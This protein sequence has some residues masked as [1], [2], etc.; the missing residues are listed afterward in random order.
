MATNR[1]TGVI[2]E[3]LTGGGDT[4]ARVSIF[5]VEI[6]ASIDPIKYTT[7][8]L[9]GAGPRRSVFGVTST[10]PRDSGS[11]SRSMTLL[12]DGTTTSDSGKPYMTNGTAASDKTLTFEILGLPRVITGYLWY[13]T[14][15]VSPIEFAF[16][17]SNDGSTWITLSA[18]DTMRG[19]GGNDPWLVRV[20]NATAYKWYRLREVGGTWNDS[21]IRQ[22]EFIISGTD[23]E[24]GNR[25]SSITAT[26]NITGAS[27]TD[28]GNLVDGAYGTNSSDSWWPD[29]SQSASGL[30]IAYQFDTPR[31]VKYARVETSGYTGDLGT[32]KWQASDDGSTWVDIGS[33]FTW[34]VTNITS[35]NPIPVHDLSSNNT[36]HAYYQMVGVSGTLVRTP[37]QIETY[38]D[39]SDGSNFDLSAAFEDGSEFI[40]N[41]SAIE[42][43]LTAGLVD[44]SRLYARSTVAY[45]LTL[46]I[47]YA[48]DSRLMAF[49]KVTIYENLSVNLSD[50]SRITLRP[51]RV[52]P[53]VRASVDFSDD[54]RFR[55]ALFNG[56]ATRGPFYFAW[57]E[58]GDVPH[59]SSFLR[60][61][62]E[63]FSLTLTQS[64]GDFARL[65]IVIKNPRVGLLAPSRKTWAWLTY[66]DGVTI[67]PVF[68]GRLIGLPS[69][70]FDT[71]VTLEFIARPVDFAAQKEALADTMRAL[72]Y[73]DPIFI[74]PDS[75]NDPDL[76]LDAR[77]ELW[78]ID[79]VTHQLTTSDLIVP[80]D[81][82]IELTEDDHLYH[83]LATS[84]G[85]VPV[86]RCRV[87]ATIPWTQI[88]SGSFS[89]SKRIVNAWPEVAD[90]YAS[91]YRG[92]LI[93]S[94]SFD[95][96]SGDWPKEGA[97]L[98]DGWSVIEGSLA[99]MTVATVPLKATDYLSGWVFA[100]YNQAT[101]VPV[102][103]YVK[104]VKPTYG[105]LDVPAVTVTIVPAGW[106]APVLRVGY[107]SSRNYSEIVT[108]D[109][110]SDMQAILTLPGDD[111]VVTLTVN[112]NSVSDV[113]RD[114][115]TPL[116]DLRCNEYVSTARGQQSVQHMILMAR[117]TLI[118][119][120]RAV[121]IDC[122]FKDFV[123][124]LDVT[125]RKGLLIHDHRLPGGEAVGK[126]TKYSLS[127]AGGKPSAQVTINSTVGYGGSHVESDGED[128][129]IDDDYVDD[130][131]VRDNVVSLVPSSDVAFT[132]PNYDANDDKVNFV[133]GLSADNAVISLQVTGGPN[134]QRAALEGYA[135]DNPDLAVYQVILQNLYTQV[136]LTMQPIGRGPYATDITI[137]TSDLIIPKQIDLEAEAIEVVS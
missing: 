8:N 65:T 20:K 136:H 5:A 80:E 68:Y 17:A 131:F 126:I 116:G 39:I 82:T 101:L 107:D 125:L 133:R 41:H 9:G 16:E 7:N 12:L 46:K 64:E 52:T 110:E 36:A 98:G 81:G 84:M 29:T 135:G 71:R 128:A 78:H 47:S 55:V 121:Q 103:S 56:V 53:L 54:S 45:P 43:H 93:M 97:S 50:E 24:V 27:G 96:L 2:T 63:I 132:V 1:T 61:D 102:G 75:W 118:N 112:T 15:P 85:D 28:I 21:N 123:Q 91:D 34:S 77:T 37:Y 25:L 124:A 120:A 58:A 38:F 70:I 79:R 11:S 122:H 14:A 40:V 10:L 119:R 48:D 23:D 115:T 72:P 100:D 51:L 89:L 117:A 22:V 109:V 94:Y 130:Y 69:N 90:S 73:Y 18:G 33:P 49:A 108:V 26:T 111:E 104:A 13:Q 95:G 6:L 92:K 99:D 114:G 137:E 59:N 88:A 42:V 60:E 62:E 105:G 74:Q 44:D 87:V 66:Y 106:G 76:V 32:W 67:K 4:S 83:G 127:Y 86:R 134:A 113:T 30:N 129:Y 3:V 57:A 35:D 19:S 31:V